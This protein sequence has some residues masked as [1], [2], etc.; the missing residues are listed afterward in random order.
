MSTRASVAWNHS[1]HL[2]EELMDD[3]LWLE[4]E[5][6][7]FEVAQWKAKGPVR[8]TFPVPFE[9]IRTVFLPKYRHF[10][11]TPA[12][13]RRRAKRVAANVERLLRKVEARKAD[14]KGT[15]TTTRRARNSTRPARRPRGGKGGTN[16]RRAAGAPLPKRE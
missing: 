3:R 2:Y 15:E 7:E 9:L 14:A 12:E 8:I 5:V 4:V 11:P 1:Y 13:R 16:P 10:P 6:Q